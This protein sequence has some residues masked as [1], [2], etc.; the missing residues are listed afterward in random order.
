MREIN[1]IYVP[2][3]TDLLRN[4]TYVSRFDSKA[5]GS[6]YRILAAHIWRL[7]KDDTSRAG[8]RGKVFSA[9][10]AEYEAGN[11]VSYFDDSKLADMLG[12]TPRYVRKLR[13]QLVEL[14]LVEA[15]KVDPKA[16]KYMY[17]LGEVVAPGDYGHIHEVL[18]MDRWLADILEV[19]KGKKES[20]EFESALQALSSKQVPEKEVDSFSEN[21][22]KELNSA[23]LGAASDI[24]M[25]K[26]GTTVPDIRNYSSGN[27]QR[28]NT[29]QDGKNPTKT[30]NGNKMNYKISPSPKGEVKKR[31]TPNFSQNSSAQMSLFDTEPTSDDYLTLLKETLGKNLVKVH[32]VVLKALKT[33]GLSETKKLYAAALMEKGVSVPPVDSPEFFVLAWEEVARNRVKLVPQRSLSAD[34]FLYAWWMFHTID[35]NKPAQRKNVTAIRSIFKSLTTKLASD[36][37]Y[38]LEVLAYARNVLRQKGD[39]LVFAQPQHFH[40]AL[41]TFHT[42]YS[43][44]KHRAEE[45][46][47][48]AKKNKPPVDEVSCPDDV[49]V[50]SDKTEMPL[51]WHI[52]LLDKQEYEP[53]FLDNASLETKARLWLKGYLFRELI[54]KPMY[55]RK[56][57]PSKCWRKKADPVLISIL[58]DFE[59]GAFPDEK[60]ECRL[61]KFL[62]LYPKGEWDEYYMCTDEEVEELATGDFVKEWE[63]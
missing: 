33:I 31:G 3:Y 56:D 2:V 52:K 4:A 28:E 16:A 24:F 26:S 45:Q 34:A 17:K 13:N 32:S 58:L 49:M 41:E 35:R 62:E 36:V 8:Y 29:V 54:P 25:D 42:Y 30:D 63:V 19:K 48:D 12:I 23:I 43:E 61:K 22:L 1:R 53:R 59:D 38:L 46:S 47:S 6:M 5:I 57:I 11:L 37:D 20:P 9:L 40:K 21:S 27:A 50:A 15:K 18:F 44:K 51:D 39:K 10:A 14:G 60:A 55:R 7:D